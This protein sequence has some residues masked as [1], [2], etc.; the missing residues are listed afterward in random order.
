[1]NI[2][3]FFIPAAHAADATTATAQ[4]GSST[5]M[6]MILILTFAF[7]YFSMWR[8]QSKRAKEHR[9]LMDGLSKEDE[10]ITS[11]GFIGKINKIQ[12][13]YVVLAVN[14]HTEITLQKSAISS[15]LPR[16][17]LKTISGSL[18]KATIKSA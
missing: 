5:P 2:L 12:D 15:V 4:Q 8:P 1:M 17:T 9:T 16:G 6:L 10:V 11:G 3:D 13:D 18:T 14:D 7:I